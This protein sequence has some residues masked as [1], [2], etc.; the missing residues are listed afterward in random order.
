MESFGV[1]TEEGVKN[2]NL[3][4]FYQDVCSK[5]TLHVYAIDSSSLLMYLVTKLSRGNS[6]DMGCIA[7]GSKL[8]AIGGVFRDSHAQGYPQDV[9]VCDLSKRKGREGDQYKWKAGPA[10][11]GG[12]PYPMVVA[13]KGKIYALAG[14]AYH[15]V[16]VAIDPT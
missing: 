1:E 12:K 8:Y 6:C 10:L 14:H 13:V 4:L 5:H 15:D 9:L 16:P 3:Y 2:R 7:H 11:N